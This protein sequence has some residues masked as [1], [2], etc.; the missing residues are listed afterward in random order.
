MMRKYISIISE[1]SGLGKGE[2]GHSIGK[3]ESRP[4]QTV[5][6]GLNAL[7]RRARNFDSISIFRLLP[8]TVGAKAAVLV[9]FDRFTVSTTLPSDRD[10]VIFLT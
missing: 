8:V 4:V 2:R 7:P 3:I 1:M 6:K 5:S 9:A 10:C